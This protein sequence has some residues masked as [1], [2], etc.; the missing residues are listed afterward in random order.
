MTQRAQATWS[1][2]RR[3]R[4]RGTMPRAQG[5]SPQNAVRGSIFMDGTSFRATVGGE[6]TFEL[7]SCY[8]PR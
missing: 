4:R 6:S 1:V 3:L 5:S 2:E 8:A 7:T